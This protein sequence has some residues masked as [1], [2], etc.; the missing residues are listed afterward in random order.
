MGDKEL[1]DSLGPELPE[2]GGY[3]LDTVASFLEETKGKCGVEAADWIPDLNLFLP[4]VQYTMSCVS[5][6]EFDKQKQGRLERL[7]TKGLS[8]TSGNGGH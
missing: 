8:L 3:T 7:M 1:T 6:S 2:L 4:S 5:V